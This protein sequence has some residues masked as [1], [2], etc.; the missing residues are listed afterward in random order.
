MEQFAVRRISLYP[1]SAI[2]LRE[3]RFQFISKGVPVAARSECNK[4]EVHSFRQ[5]GMFVDP[6]LCRR[7]TPH[8]GLHPPE[9]TILT[10]NATADSES[11]QQQLLL[12][13]PAHFPEL[14]AKPI[15]A[16]GS[17]AEAD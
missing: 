12:H 15:V 5:D 3:R 11:P 4:R 17:I 9:S 13:Q 10:V 14:G 16:C 1:R 7:T 6:V 8:R 2:F